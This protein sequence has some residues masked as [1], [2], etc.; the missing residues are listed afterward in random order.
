MTRF[1]GIALALA[2]AGLVGTATARA[3]TVIDI[4]QQPQLGSWTPFGESG[5]ATYGQTFTVG[6]DRWLGSFSLYLQGELTSPISVRAYVQAWDG[7]MVTGPVLFRSAVTA[8]AGSSAP[9]ELVFDALGTELQAGA[10]YVAYLSVSGLS[11]GSTETVGMPHSGDFGHDLLADGGFV[12][13]DN[14]DDLDLLGQ[15]W[16]DGFE[17]GNDVWFKATLASSAPL[18]PPPAVPEPASALLMLGG[19]AL[20]AGTVR[21]RGVHG[22]HGS[23]R[24]EGG[25]LA[26]VAPTTHAGRAGCSDGAAR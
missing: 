12:W 7:A 6:S 2:I 22:I 11:T 1:P 8:Y 16:W 21:R 14:G 23:G 9:L 13:A 10:K 24:A 5:T 18:T 15:T 25:P 26:G 17:M 19:L 3:D 4:T 20:A